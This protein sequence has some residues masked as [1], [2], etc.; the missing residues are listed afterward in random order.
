MA[1]LLLCRASIRGQKWGDNTLERLKSNSDFGKVYR[2]GKYSAD[3]LVVIHYLPNKLDYSR[4]G[5]SV[6]KKVGNS[7]MRNLIKRRMREIVRNFYPHIVP[8]Y[9]IVISA[10]MGANKATF[11]GLNHSLRQAL[12]RSSLLIKEERKPKS[13]N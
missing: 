12:W 8:G 3:S 5:F 11:N 4:I 10:R 7:V 2:E 1:P 9:D 13:G 6:S